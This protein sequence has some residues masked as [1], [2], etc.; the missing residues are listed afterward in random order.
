MESMKKVLTKSEVTSRF[1]TIGFTNEHDAAFL[2][3]IAQA[4]SDLGNFFYIN[5]EQANYPDQI[6]ECLT[7]S[8][9]MAQEE[10]GLIL[11]LSSEKG[12]FEKKKFVLSKYLEA[13]NDDAEDQPQE[14][15]RKKDLEEVKI[16]DLQF[17]FNTTI[18]LKEEE[19]KDLHGFVQL[20]GNQMGAIEFEKI[21]V[22]NP[23]N[24]ALAHA[25]IQLINK[26][27]FDAIQ[28]AQ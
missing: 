28:E 21:L 22:E 3:I 12:R 10:E 6:Q 18:F 9:Q 11:K 13:V 7:S 17:D 26:L 19:L 14:G 25:S 27:I 8:L 4:G 16:H 1:L 15:K 23:G 24:E 5:T 2:N 20:P